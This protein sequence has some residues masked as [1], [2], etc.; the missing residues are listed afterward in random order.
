MSRTIRKKPSVL[1][2]NVPGQYSGD[3]LRLELP[4]TVAELAEAQDHSYSYMDHMNEHF[5][6]RLACEPW[7]WNNRTKLL[8]RS[9]NDFKFTNITFPALRHR[10]TILAMTA[11]FS[12]LCTIDDLVEAMDPGEAQQVLQESIKIMKMPYGP[13]KNHMSVEDTPAERI[14]HITYAFCR[15]LQTLLSEFT[16]RRVILAASD[17]FGGIMAESPIRATGIAPANMDEY[18]KIRVRTIGIAP[19]AMLVESETLP[20]N[21][22]KS[23][24]LRALEKEIYGVVGLQ[25]DVLGL[26]KDLREGEVMNFVVVDSGI[27]LTSS[28]VMTEDGRQKVRE[29]VAHLVIHHNERLQ[30]AK[31]LRKAIASRPDDSV[32]K[33]SAEALYLLSATHFYWASTAKRYRVSY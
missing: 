33:E 13:L 24:A 25:N 9:E 17:V 2:F 14:I 11:W 8:S 21:H 23:S 16:Y 29:G 27:N 26:E 6:F 3:D 31:R 22:A 10:E 4:I 28:D 32:E 19:L 7:M 18:M 30:L 15:H 5:D 20:Q 12:Y 1:A